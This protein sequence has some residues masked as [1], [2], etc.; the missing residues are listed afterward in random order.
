MI[1]GKD[2][3]KIYKEINSHNYLINCYKHL[4]RIK[5]IHFLFILIE[6]LLNIFQ[7][8]ET[9][10]RNFRLDN[11]SK[12]DKNKLNL[13]SIIIQSF[14]KIQAIIKLIAIILY[15]ILFDGFYIF[16]KIKKFKL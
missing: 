10:V 5:G 14:E 9:F 15:I 7:E 6:L 11:I 13:V 8:L 12:N 4:T 16:I 1:Y 3:P 2:V